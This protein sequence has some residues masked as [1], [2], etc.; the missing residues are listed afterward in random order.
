MTEL[1]KALETLRAN[2]DDQKAQSGFYDLFL[3]AV[4]FVPTMTQSIGTDED[5]EEQEA[6]LPL[7]IENDGTDYLLFFDQRQ[8]LNDW[9][10]KEAPCVQL[11][12]HVLAEMTTAEL[13]WAM[14]IGTDY[15]KQFAPDEI[16]W[17]KDVVSRCKAEAEN[18]CE[19][20]GEALNS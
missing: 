5:N 19:N 11:P 2:P 8:R 3:N 13:Y 9:A 18:G 15:S 4:F 17:L 7:I 20:G 12:G 1:D 14:N 10:E 16:A 6:E